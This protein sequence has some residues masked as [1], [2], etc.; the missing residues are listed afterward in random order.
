MIN[1]GVWFFENKKRILNTPNNIPGNTVT[2]LD[3]ID[4]LGIFY[5]LGYNAI[6]SKKKDSTQY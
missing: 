1:N 4:I 6:A 2:H 5:S 3:F